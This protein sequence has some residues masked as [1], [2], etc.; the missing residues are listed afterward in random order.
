M[1]LTRNDFGDKLINDFIDVFTNYSINNTSYGRFVLHV[2]LGQALY[3]NVYYS[4][5]A[6]KI[7]PRLHLLFIKPQ[8][9]GKGS[10]YDCAVKFAEDVGLDFRR[11]TET[12]DAALIGSK[13]IPILYLSAYM[14]MYMRKVIAKIIHP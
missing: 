1:A 13:K 3:N 11:I 7:G 10:G 9:T 12:T 14:N 5:G 6:R 4:Q 8:G 2:I